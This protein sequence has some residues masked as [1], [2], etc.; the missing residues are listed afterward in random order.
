LSLSDLI[1]H[2]NGLPGGSEPVFS[3]PW[4]AQAFALAVALNENGLFTWS[5]WAEALSVELKSPRA[6]DDASDYFMHWLAALEKLV[7]AKGVAGYDQIDA[8]SDAW[9]RAALAT[10]HG[11]PILLENDPQKP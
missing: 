5:E 4:E 11:S 10:P 1:A 2:S 9:Q 7:E 3:E 6:R 8:L